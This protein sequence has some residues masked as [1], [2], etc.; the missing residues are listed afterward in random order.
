MLVTTDNTNA[1]IHMRK[2]PAREYT[3]LMFSIYLCT[4][5]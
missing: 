3:M 5:A 1:V 2:N 4:V